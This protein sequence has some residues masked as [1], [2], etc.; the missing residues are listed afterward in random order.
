VDKPA[1]SKDK[2]HSDFQS[3]RS[4]RRHSSCQRG[5]SPVLPGG[6]PISKTTRARRQRVAF[7]ARTAQCIG[8]VP[9]SAQTSR[10]R[11]FQVAVATLMATVQHF[12][13]LADI[14]IHI[15]HIYSR[16]SFKNKNNWCFVSWFCT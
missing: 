2:H 9:L 7:S 16:N 4:R 5:G 10:R 15:G 12:V 8:A 1:H 6:R 11:A 3:T 14:G 13:F